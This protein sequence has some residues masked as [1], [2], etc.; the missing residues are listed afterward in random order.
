MSAYWC[1]LA[2]LGGNVAEAGVLVD[3]GEDGRI[4]AVTSGVPAPLS[5]AVRNEQA[6][7]MQLADES[8]DLVDLHPLRRKS[9]LVQ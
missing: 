8:R 7:L 4:A 5:G 6:G 9:R 3:V 1:E 2:W